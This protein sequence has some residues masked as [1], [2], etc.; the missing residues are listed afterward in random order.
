M[1]RKTVKHNP[2]HFVVEQVLQS[3]ERA[4]KHFPDTSEENASIE[5]AAWALV[6]IEREEY[7]DEFRQFL[8]RQQLPVRI[9]H[10]FPKMLDA[11]RWL[12]T[13]PPPARGTLVKVEEKTY[14]VWKQKDG[15][16]LLLPSFTVEELD[17][18]PD[19]E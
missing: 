16:L 3:L 13:P 5:L 2:T 19:E 12:N 8:M 18:M 10:E 1:T 6:F 17:A 15:T 4:A 9:E 14:A 7:L 11:L